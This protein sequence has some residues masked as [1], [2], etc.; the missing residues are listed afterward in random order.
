MILRVVKILWEISLLMVLFGLG[1]CDVNPGTESRF[2]VPADM[3]QTTEEQDDQQPRYNILLIL[4]DDLGYDHY[5]FAGHPVVK[6]PSID[7]LSNRSIRFPAAYVSSVCRPTFAT[8]LTGL[9]EHRHGTTYIGGPQLGDFLT[10]ADR[11]TTV[12]YRSFQAGKFW[13]GP[14]ARHGFTDSAPLGG[15]T[16]NKKIG[17]VTIE[18]VVRFMH[19]T[20]APWF[21]W[22]SPHMPHSPHNAPDRHKASYRDAELDDATLDY[23]AMISWFDEVV[24]ELL[25]EVDEDT[26][27]LYMADNGFV[28]SDWPEVPEEKSKG[29]SYERGIRTQLLIYHPEYEAVVRTE[30]SQAVDVTATILAIAGADYSGLPGRD[31]L[32]PYS[33]EEPAFGSRSSI[34]A[35]DGRESV[36]E[37]RWIRVGDWKLVDIENS[38]SDRLHNLSLDPDEKSNYIVRPEHASILAQLRLELEKKW[39]E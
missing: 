29:S 15:A 30:L 17:R 7:A 36:L 11:L 25:R 5:G 39:R 24:G 8:L 28:Q 18:P 19:D 37:E 35:T 31:L 34:F 38:D 14:Q 32:V 26:V 21:V 13:E 12:G 9:P 16:G 27:I 1:A 33:A 20:S 3:A 2:A 4:A 6:T 22:F 23:F 10:I